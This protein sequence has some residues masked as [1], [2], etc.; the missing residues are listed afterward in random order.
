MKTLCFAG[1]VVLFATTPTLL[2][3]IL[4]AYL[5]ASLFIQ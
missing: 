2:F 4:L 1:C 3:Y 5:C